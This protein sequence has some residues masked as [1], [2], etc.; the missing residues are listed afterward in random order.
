MQ[1]NNDKSGPKVE[2]Q[3]EKI[4]R[5]TQ[6]MLD[7]DQ[8]L[9]GLGPGVRLVVSRDEPSW[10]KGFLEEMDISES[11]NPLSLNYLIQTWGG[12][13]LK[14]RFRRSDGTWMKHHYVDLYSYEPLVWGRPARKP[15]PN[16]HMGS[17]TEEK[18]IQVVQSA[19]DSRLDTLNLMKLMQE[20]RSADMQA[21]AA[22]VKTA[23]PVAQT[24]QMDPFGMM[25]GMIRLLGQAMLLRQPVE[26]TVSGGGDDEVFGLLNKALDVLSSNHRREDVPRITA[27]SGMSPTP[28][29]SRPLYQELAALDPTQAVAELRNA[30]AEMEPDKQIQTLGELIAHIDQI[31]GRETLLQALEQRGILESEED[32]D[33]PAPVNRAS[34]TRG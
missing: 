22:L 16:P 4:D 20:M 3:P 26:T 1:E 2:I 5:D 15:S 28:A 31:G 17:E 6:E 10:C 18:A 25:S 32:E 24:P 30:V 13:K 14:L 9:S 11:V 7:L 8:Y 27:P 33:E 34:H 23:A 12:H 21:M 19:P 29:T